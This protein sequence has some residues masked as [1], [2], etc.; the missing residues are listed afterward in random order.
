M[1]AAKFSILPHPHTFR[2]RRPGP[3]SAYL[4]SHSTASGTVNTARSCYH[5][6]ALRPARLNADCRPHPTTVAAAPHY[7]HTRPPDVPARLVYQR[8]LVN[9]YRTSDLCRPRA[10]AR[11]T[12]TS[13]ERR[14]FALTRSGAGVDLPGF[15]RG[16]SDMS[17]REDGASAARGARGGRARRIA[18]RED[19]RHRPWRKSDFPSD[20]AAFERCRVK[21]HEDFPR[22]IYRLF[23][24]LGIQFRWVLTRGTLGRA[25][26][27]QADLAIDDAKENAWMALYEHD[28]DTLEDILYRS[29]QDL[30]AP[31]T[32]VMKV[33]DTHGSAQQLCAQK[34]WEALLT[35]FPLDHKRMQTVLL[36]REIARMMRWDGD[37]KGAVNKHFAS[38]TE[39]HHTMGYI[40]NFSIEDVLKSVLMA[41]LKASN[42]RFLRDAYHK[43]LDDLDD[44]KD[45]TFA[46]IQDA[47]ARQFRRHPDERPPAAW[48][49]DPPGTPR[50]HLGPS[51]ATRKMRPQT[52]DPVSV[53]AYLC[54]FLH[55]HG[56]KPANV[57]KKAGLRNEAPA[58]WHSGDAVRALYTASLPFMPQSLY[59]DSESASDDDAS[60]ALVDSDFDA[61]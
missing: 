16:R 2:C 53:S 54:N 6:C 10:R 19:D 43:V 17:D 33:F 22:H 44:E 4:A 1:R 30:W 52:G 12:G 37:S 40:G 8:L 55:D 38:V 48:N 58:H 36:A 26:V 5:G 20:D 24:V 56:V 46:L 13:S 3:A 60:V 18:D 57:L 41:T 35:A 9:T 59:S 27:S 34:V 51:G 47:C 45:L 21:S 49:H 29:L 23:L 39:L 28:R 15:G 31:L 61:S 7:P 42:N 14:A 32:D 50:R 11:P 25:L